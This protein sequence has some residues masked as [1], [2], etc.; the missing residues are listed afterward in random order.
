MPTAGARRAAAAGVLGAL[1]G[2]LLLAVGGLRIVQEQRSALLGG[3]L[4]LR[5]AWADQM[6][7]EAV[8]AQV[9]APH[10]Q[11]HRIFA[12]LDEPVR[13]SISRDIPNMVDTALEPS[14]N[15]EDKLNRKLLRLQREKEALETRKS[16][17]I[18]G[19]ISDRDWQER[20][21]ASQAVDAHHQR[22]RSALE[23]ARR[24]QWSQYEKAAKRYAS[25]TRH[26]TMQ[27]DEY[28]KRRGR[29]MA[30]IKEL[31]TLL[32]EGDGQLTTAPENDHP[33]S[34]GSGVP[35]DG[36]LDG[37]L[38]SIEGQAAALGD[39]T[40]KQALLANVKKLHSIIAHGGSEHAKVLAVP[41]K[42][43]CER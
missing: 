35:A 13:R 20:R 10:R 26:S 25:A 32:T 41:D 18:H 30:R 23:R 3:L 7:H 36:D 16:D 37:L 31:D 29:V 22:L 28:L 27:A 6:E 24:E 33:A 12:P 4:P 38:T 39:D 43:R 9:A 11:G 21:V 19:L 1:C 2:A 40:E 17:I 5:R 15:Y 34:S 8:Y 14:N 42:R